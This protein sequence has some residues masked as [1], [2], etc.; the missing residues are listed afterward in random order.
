MIFGHFG[1]FSSQFLALFL[2]KFSPKTHTKTFEFLLFSN[3]QVV[4][5]LLSSFSP[6][7][8]NLGFEVWGVQ[9]Y[10]FSYYLYPFNFL[11]LSC[12]IVLSSIFYS[13]SSMSTF[14]LTCFITL[15]LLSQPSRA[16]IYLNS[17]FFAQ[18]YMFRSFLP[19]FCLDYVFMC[20]LPCFCVWIYMLCLRPYLDARPSTLQLYILLFSLSCVWLFGQGVDL[21]LVVQADIHAP[22]F[23]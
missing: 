19:C 12:F 1:A 11:H 14:F 16:R 7:F 6:W 17:L 8:Q 18:I 20:F 4:V 5:F 2:S 10:L 13:L 23:Q 9:M 22:I 3:N 21:D 15:L